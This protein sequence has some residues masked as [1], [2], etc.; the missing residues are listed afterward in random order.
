MRWSSD[1]E[2][3]AGV[4]LGP[5]TLYGALSRLEEPGADRRAPAEG[6]RRPYRITAAGAGALSRAAHNDGERGRHRSHSAAQRSFAGMSTQGRR[7]P[8]PAAGL[9][10]AP[11]PRGLAQALRERG[12]GRCIAEDPPARAGSLSLVRGAADARLRPGALGRG[13]G[14][15]ARMRV[16]MGGLFGCWIAVSLNGVGFQKETEDVG[17]AAAARRH[18]LLAIAH[19]VI[20]AGAR[21]WAPL[22]DR[23]SAACRWYRRRCA[24]PHGD[25]DWPADSR[26]A[27]PR[28]RP[29]CL[30]CGHGLLV[31]I[32]PGTQR[33]L[34]SEL[35]LL[36]QAPWRIGGWTCAAVC[37][38]A[39]RVV[40]RTGRSPAPGALRR[41]SLAAP[42]LALAMV[43]ITA[44]A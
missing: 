27:L 6:R 34:H 3:M 1:I 44:R 26:A 24:S 42:V 30:R 18:P 35:R 37:A 43:T 41:A 11:L 25:A 29:R 17:F 7:L 19:D 4:H 8:T 14:A 39:P 12:R 10:V 9:L 23:G 5:G 28:A 15:R 13:A 40:M 36:F 33:S 38:L 20:V 22:R 21:E 31:V 16:S 2:E 32:S